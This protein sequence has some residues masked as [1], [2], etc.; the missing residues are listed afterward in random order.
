MR[1][2]AFK[3]INIKI[4]KFSFKSQYYAASENMYAKT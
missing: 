4:R 1:F 3:L 2:T